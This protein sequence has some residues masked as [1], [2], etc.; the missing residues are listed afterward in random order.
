MNNKQSGFAA[1]EALVIVLVVGVLAFA[2]W[3]VYDSRNN[4]AP[5]TTASNSD[6]TPAV[7]KADDLDA[8]ND[9]LN[10]QDIDSKLDT[11]EI[12]AALSE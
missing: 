10:D 2:G 1:I 12:D 11:S 5:A 6:S 8:A 4:S 3:K 9:Y 7:Q